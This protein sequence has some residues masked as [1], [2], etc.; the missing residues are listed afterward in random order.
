LIKRFLAT[1]LSGPTG[2]L[3]GWLADIIS[4]ILGFTTNVKTEP[5][6]FSTSV[7]YCRAPHAAA[8]TAR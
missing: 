2:W 1:L 8:A 7:I 3:A 5:N 6:L 4:A